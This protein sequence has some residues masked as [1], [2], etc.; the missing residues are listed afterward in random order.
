VV[1]AKSQRREICESC[2]GSG[3]CACRH[4]NEDIKFLEY[5]EVNSNERNLLY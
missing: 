2:G 4:E 5:D 1:N 3:N